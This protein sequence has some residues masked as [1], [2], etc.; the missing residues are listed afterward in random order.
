MVLAVLIVAVDPFA[1]GE[2]RKLPGDAL[3]VTLVADDAVLRVKSLADDLGVNRS[4]RSLRSA[5]GPTYRVTLVHI[6]TESAA[7]KG[8][9]EASDKEGEHERSD[10][11]GRQG[12][13]VGVATAFILVLVMIVM[14]GW[15]YLVA[16]EPLSFFFTGASGN[17]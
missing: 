11:P 15:S 9:I 2:R 8:Q 3:T 4:C 16:P 12:R 17:E 1:A 7:V 6:A 14:H 5:S 13:P 10:K